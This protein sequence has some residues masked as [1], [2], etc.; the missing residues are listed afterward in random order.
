MS[1]LPS[2][3][4]DSEEAEDVENKN[5]EAK[6]AENELPN[7]GTLRRDFDEASQRDS[8]E[9]AM[10]D[11]IR[12]DRDEEDVMEDSDYE[13]FV[14]DTNATKDRQYRAWQSAFHQKVLPYERRKTAQMY[15]QLED[16]DV[17]AF[18]A[19]I[20]K[21]GQR[22]RPPWL[23]EKDLKDARYHTHPHYVCRVTNKHSTTSLPSR[24]NF[25]TKAGTKPIR[26]YSY[27]WT[28]YCDKKGTKVLTRRNGKL[29]VSHICHNHKCHDRAH[30]TLEPMWL[31]NM[32]QVC[33]ARLQ[34]G[35]SHFTCE[36]PG[37]QCYK[38]LPPSGIRPMSK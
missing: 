11:E 26:K 5:E 9:L 4:E 7:S 29:T 2:D 17:D 34:R 8:E 20:E 35:D 36:H 37:V 22:D 25:A 6:N 38:R 24:Y 3:D 18:R 23:N 14:L 32:R 33:L 15:P 19:A 12:S 27:Q 13:D 30:P 1:S 28:V 10:Y 31:N 16:M 21:D